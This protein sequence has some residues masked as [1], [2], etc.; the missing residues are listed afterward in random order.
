MLKKLASFIGIIVILVVGAISGEVGK[1]IGNTLVPPTQ[2][3]PE[4]VERKL[5]EGFQE[6]AR[7]INQT[8]PTMLD[9]NT[10]VD[11]ATVGPGV[12][13]TYHYTFPRY[14]SQ[15]IS[16]SWLRQNLLPTVK[17]NVCRNERMKL[18]LQYGGIYA[19]SYSGND[20]VRISRFEIDR[21]DCGFRKIT[22]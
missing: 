20:G 7:Q 8:T 11:R 15:D 10:R 3:N 9:E 19:Y 14:S 16:E 1:H 13:L 4:D 6:A 17:D 22:P 12:V 5:I 18:S 21:N 2:T